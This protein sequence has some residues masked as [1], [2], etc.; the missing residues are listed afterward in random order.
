MACSQAFDMHGKK[1][2]DVAFNMLRLS[3]G[4][5]QQLRNVNEHVSA[6]QFDEVAQE[7]M[8]V[9]ES[10]ESHT[11]Y[12]EHVQNDTIELNMNEGFKHREALMGNW[13]C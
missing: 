5:F 12:I 8:E 3:Q 11:N 1:D 2:V 9:I 4:H 10:N 13:Y 6:A 7:N